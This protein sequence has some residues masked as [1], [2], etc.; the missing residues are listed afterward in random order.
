MDTILD[1][2]YHFLYYGPSPRPPSYFALEKDQP[3]PGRV[4][5]FDSLSKILA[6]GIR[7]G[8]VSGPEVLVQ[9][10][11]DHVRRV[12]HHVP[13]CTRSRQESASQSTVANLQPNTLAEVLAMAVLSRWG[14][15]GFF[16]HT[17]R[18]AEFY[19]Q[20]RDV[21]QAAMLRHLSGLAEWS[22]PEA[23]MFMWYVLS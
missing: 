23:G 8:F 1:D 11:A 22:V 19:R 4:L 17:D 16:Q 14:F 7:L 10:M 15:E 20:K 3:E 21:F 18:V 5:R 2:P 6:A 12:R 13:E 9:A